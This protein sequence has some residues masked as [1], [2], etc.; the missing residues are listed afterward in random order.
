MEKIAA[1]GVN[2]GAR[3]E[4]RIDDGMGP[5]VFSLFWHPCYLVCLDNQTLFSV[6]FAPLMQIVTKKSSSFAGIRYTKNGTPRKKVMMFTGKITGARTTL[7]RVSAPSKS[8]A[9]T[10]K[11]SGLHTIEDKSLWIMVKCPH[12]G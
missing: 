10:R 1:C 5:G 8:K 11:H 2:G 9:P 7:A 12:L 6:T 3:P 4:K